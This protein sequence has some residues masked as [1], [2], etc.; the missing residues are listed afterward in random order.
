MACFGN[1]QAF[2]VEQGAAPKEVDAIVNCR[3]AEKGRFLAGVSGGVIVKPNDLVS[4]KA[5]KV[6]SYPQLQEKRP[7]NAGKPQAADRWWWD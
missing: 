3:V 1:P 6:E 7:N 4:R 5:I 2:V